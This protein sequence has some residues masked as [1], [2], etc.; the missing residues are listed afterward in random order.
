MNSACADRV[1]FVISVGLA[2]WVV[3]Q[4]AAQEP[5]A[6]QADQPQFVRIT[7][8]VPTSQADKDYLA[9]QRA[10][11]IDLP[12]PLA[13]MSFR[14]RQMF[15]EEVYMQRREKALVFLSEHPHDSRRWYVVS[16][17]EPDNPRF[18]L[19]WA[20]P[21][22]DKDKKDF[23]ANVDEAAAAAWKRKVNA[24]NAQM[25]VAE[26]VPPLL[27]KELAVK[28]AEDERNQVFHA[29]WRSGVLA[30]DFAVQD[31]AGEEVRLSDFRGKTVILDF[32]ATWCGPCKAAMPHLQELA[33]AYKDQGL[34]VLSVATEDERA[35]FEKFVKTNQRQGKF[36]DIRW[37]H[38]QAERGAERISKALYD[39]NAIPA[40]FIIDPAGEVVDVVVGYSEGERILDAALPKAGIKVDPRIVAEGQADLGRRH[41]V[42]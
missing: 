30:P 34:V 9:F 13:E 22:S 23:I 25:A 16:S 5:A 12:K 17:L 11:G 7:P 29:H 24:L 6:D 28:S 40:Q 26:D 37:A 20:P 19:E 27:K 33:A 35:D 39:V 38:D 42:E 15:A 41:G 18:V 21:G 2:L 8:S 36:P 4:S 32:W 31:L 10:F 14:E 3:Q 1:S